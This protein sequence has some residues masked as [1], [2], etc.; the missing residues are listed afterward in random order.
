MSRTWQVVGASVRGTS[1]FKT[2]IPCQDACAYM[3]TD[4]GIL[5]AAV[6]D[7]AGS[8][9]RSDLGAQ[10]AVNQAIEILFGR[11]LDGRP[12]SHRAWGE[13]LFETFCETRRRVLGLVEEQGGQSREFACTLTILIADPNWL[14]SG[15]IG[16]GFAAAQTA[17]GQL[18]AVAAPQRGEYADS[19]YF[20]TADDAPERFEGRVYRQGRDIAAVRS[21]AV[22][23]DGLIN[24][25][26]DKRSGLPHQPFFEPLMEVPGNIRNHET[27]LEELYNFLVSDRINTR[28]DDDKTL[29]LAGRPVR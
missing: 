8:A 3:V 24:L 1:H 13:L 15:Q 28:T 5:L 19:T 16:D 18:I 9:A 27:A 14:I 7:G 26:I 12:A 21:L 11:L 2:M 23:T 20:I 22:M 17:D 25:A 29:V 6:S 10:Q 4:A